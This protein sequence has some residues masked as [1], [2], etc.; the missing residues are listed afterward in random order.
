MGLIYGEMDKVDEAIAYVKKGLAID[1][2]AAALHL[3]LASGYY[4]KGDSWGAFWE[5]VESLR[6]KS[7]GY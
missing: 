6:L 4:K 2:N 7:L 1:N 5:G 3:L